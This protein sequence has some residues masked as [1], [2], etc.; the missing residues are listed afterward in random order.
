MVIIDMQNWS[1]SQPLNGPNIGHDVEEVLIDRAIPAARRAGIQ[2]VWLN[3]GL[4]Q[5][6]VDHMPPSL[7]RIFG[8]QMDGTPILDRG[9][10]SDMGVIETENGQRVAGG[11]FLMKGHWNTALHLPLE[12]LRQASLR[13]DQPDELIYKTRICG[14][15]ENSSRLDSFL[16]SRGITT[17]LF[18]GVNVEFCVLATMAAANLRDYNTIL[19]SDCTGTTN[20]YEPLAASL[21]VTRKGWGF[22]SSITDLEKGL[23]EMLDREADVRTKFPRCRPNSAITTTY[24]SV[25]VNGR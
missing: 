15:S 14:M 17:L 20:G 19:L 13:L 25:L 18:G 8:F 7:Q 16:Q 11:R 12:K 9:I 4:T 3:W 5:D 21:Q 22:C 23:D 6:D 2:V 10:G 1:L 24:A